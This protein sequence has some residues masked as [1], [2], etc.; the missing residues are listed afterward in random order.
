MLQKK[1]FLMKLYMFRRIGRFINADSILD[2]ANLMAYCKNSPILY[3]DSNGTE[4]YIVGETNA[5]HVRFRTAPIMTSDT[6]ITWL[7]KGKE[8][9]LKED[10][11][12]KGWYK[13]IIG[14]KEGYVCAEYINEIVNGNSIVWSYGNNDLRKSNY[15]S[16]YVAHLQE[17]L[18]EA[19]FDIDVDGVFGDETEKAVI[20]YQRQRRILHDEPPGVVTYLMMQVLGPWTE[21][22]GG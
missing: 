1:L 11:E 8:L 14:D 2:N 5:E 9:I 12:H 19:G 7:P 15:K 3:F 18:V 13:T 4:R 6:Q 17:K 20:L 22:W 10:A 16:L 21:D